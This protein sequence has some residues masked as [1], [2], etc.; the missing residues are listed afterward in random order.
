MMNVCKRI[1]NKAVTRVGVFFL[2]M[3]MCFWL[4]P[5]G[6]VVS[7]ADGESFITGISLIQGDLGSLSLEE[8]GY[9]VIQQS[10]NPA[11]SEGLYLGYQTGGEG[12]AIRDICVS[13]SGSGSITV[14]GHSYQ[15]A[16][17]ISLNSGADGSGLYLYVSHDEEAGEP[18]RGIS[19]QAKQTREGYSDDSPILASDGSELVVTDDGK[20][21]DFDEGIADSELYLRMYK[22]D[23]YR[24]YVE[25][26]VV[27]T[28][29]SEEAAINKLAAK[30]CTYFVNYDIGD[31][32]TVM[33]GYT[34][35]SDETKALRSLAAIG[36]DINEIASGADDDTAS[37]VVVSSSGEGIYIKDALYTPV[38]DGEVKGDTAYTFYM[39]TDE[40][41]GEPVID[42][43]ACGYDPAEFGLKDLNTDEEPEA[44]ASPEP[45]E[46]AEATEEPQDGE[47]QTSDDGEDK[48]DQPEEEKEDE[49]AEDKEEPKEDKAEE[50]DE[51]PQGD[52]E[53]E[54]TVSQVNTGRNA[55]ARLC[56]V[57][58]NIN[59]IASAEEPVERV[60]DG[61]DVEEQSDV[62]SDGEQAGE[63]SVSEEQATEEP[64]LE[65]APEISEKKGLAKAYRLY[66]EIEMKDWISGYFLRGGGQIGAKYLYDESRYAAAAESSEKLWISNIYCSDEDGK[67]FVNCIGYVARAGDSDTDIFEESV[68]Y[69]KAED[70]ANEQA[71][72]DSTASVFGMNFGQV[73]MFSMIVVILTAIIMSLGFKLHKTTKEK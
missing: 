70:L 24:P 3:S 48:A 20:V 41:A 57:G 42:L 13:S 46:E 64:I 26:V 45:T 69:N 55:M 17:D 44:S 60:V 47:D 2:T 54:E 59:S 5:V 7:K 22:G 25:K 51:E 61:E 32:K 11:G 67:Q 16:S 36:G 30:R 52:G 40:K 66:S 68:P 27:A 43:V 71:E 28:A 37:D 8:A 65:P 73:A 35:T 14:D 39:S 1:K 15:K 23:I 62:S 50:P 34:R 33:V 72:A 12:G 38:Q 9:N 58:L 10:L 31:E 4:L 18:L 63:S 56:V 29:D 53:A 6:V 21:A 19:F 49:Q